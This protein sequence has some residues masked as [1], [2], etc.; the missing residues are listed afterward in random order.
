MV[1]SQAE[2]SQGEAIRV[3]EEEGREVGEDVSTTPQVVAGSLAVVVGG[4]HTC[5]SERRNRET[6][7][8]TS[9]R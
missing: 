8:P 3:V 9:S 4:G 7:F 6:S 1:A 5:T 2:G